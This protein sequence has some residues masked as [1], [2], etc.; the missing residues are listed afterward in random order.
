[1]QCDSL[2]SILPDVQES[3]VILHVC[4]FLTKKWSLWDAT[5]ISRK[6][7]PW[8]FVVLVILLWWICR[9]WQKRRRVIKYFKKIPGPPGLPILGNIVELNV[10]HDE[11]FQRLMAM[12]FLWGHQ[13]G[14]NKAWLGNHP[15]V[16]LSKATTVEPI[17]GSNRH[18]DKS[19]DYRFLQPWLGTGLLT[20]SGRKWHNR[21]KILTPTFHFKIL[22]DFVEIFAEQT[23][24]LVN[25]VSCEIG[26][27]SFNIFPY[28][29]LCAL[30]IICETAMG[31]QVFAQYDSD[32]DYVRAVYEIGSIIQTRQATLWYHPDCLFRLTSLYKKHQEC[33]RILHGFSNKVIAERRREIKRTRNE[34]VSE[35]EGRKR[36]AFLDLLI[37]ASQNGTSLSDEDI[38][39]EVDTF[40]FEGHDTTSSAVSW[41]LYLLGCH[42]NIQNEVVAELA[43]IFGEND[44]G[45]RATL[46]D[47]QSMKCLERCIKETLRL[48]PSVPL[49]ARRIS[50]DVRIGKFLIPEGTT[51]MVILPMLHRD[52]AVFPNP[53][54][55]DPNRFLPENCTGRHPYAYIPFSAGPRNCIGQKFALLEEKVIISG[56]LRKF[57]IEAAERREE[58]SLTGELVIRA[59]NGLHVRVTRRER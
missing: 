23:E 36:L 7:N 15:Y 9:W 18:I 58:I 14:I 51:A 29:T 55:F 52:P 24:L 37:E 10:D 38:R 33:I 31:R 40:M 49:L 59:K 50:E 44:N 20:G 43:D 30:D 11:L 8:L 17:L 26:Q 34:T 5:V 22:E 2:Q 42:P 25:K 53:D 13:E 35:D 12:R 32:S 27:D 1:M 39:E 45:R 41:T 46:R 4:V 47:L 6:M 54:K 19:S 57:K 3:S 21:R 48:Y 28:V 16:F 56:V